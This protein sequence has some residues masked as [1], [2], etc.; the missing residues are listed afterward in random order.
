MYVVP[1]DSSLL[2]SM[3]MYCHENN[4]SVKDNNRYVSLGGLPMLAKDLGSWKLI[5]FPMKTFNYTLEEFTE[6]QRQVCRRP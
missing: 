3:L 4:N 1:T 6:E 2:A 5:S